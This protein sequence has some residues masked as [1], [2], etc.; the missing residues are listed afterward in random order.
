M[1]KLMKW[2]RLLF[3]QHETE[4]DYYRIEHL[5]YGEQKNW[6]DK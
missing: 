1:T 3:S 2:L 4:S 6:R 5:G